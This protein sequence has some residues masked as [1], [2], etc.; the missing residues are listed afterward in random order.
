MVAWTVLNYPC[1]VPPVR[2]YM[3]ERSKRQLIR[4]ALGLALDRARHSSADVPK[5]S[6]PKQI[7]DSRGC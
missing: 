6:W 7:D 4:G 1:R 5:A 2:D 3:T